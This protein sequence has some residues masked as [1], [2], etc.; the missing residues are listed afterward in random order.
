MEISELHREV[1]NQ[2]ATH[3]MSSEEDLEGEAERD[4]GSGGGGAG[5]GRGAGAL[6]RGRGPGGRIG[7]GGGG[8]RGEVG[9]RGLEVGAVGH[10]DVDPELLALAAVARRAA[11]VV[12][13]ARSGEVEERV[14]VGE[15][16]H[17]ARQ[18]AGREGL[19]RQLQHRV[20][21]RRVQE[22]CDRE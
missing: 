20:L 6:R 17:G 14:A 9:G 5:R 8:E 12:G 1:A 11:G 18:V 3:Q 21:A 2:L 13:A 19:R 15:P 22:P 4:D 10:G 7:G 16:G